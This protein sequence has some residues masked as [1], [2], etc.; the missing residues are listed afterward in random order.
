MIETAVNIRPASQPGRM[1][2]WLRMS[3]CDTDWGHRLVLFV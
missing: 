3:D 2:A 1:I